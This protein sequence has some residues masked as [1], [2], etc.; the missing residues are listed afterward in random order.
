MG[1]LRHRPLDT[2]V[3]RCSPCKVLSRFAET[4]STRH[5]LEALCIFGFSVSLLSPPMNRRASP[6]Q[7]HDIMIHK[8]YANF[9]TSTPKPF[10]TSYRIFTNFPNK[11]FSKR[12]PRQSSKTHAKATNSPTNS[13]RQTG[14]YGCNPQRNY[15]PTTYKI[16]G[17][18]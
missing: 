11:L 9:K 6:R 3:L 15:E 5:L 13:S 14:S 4:S 7:T 2:D 17:S 8:A 1:S 16:R 10:K 12:S 18:V